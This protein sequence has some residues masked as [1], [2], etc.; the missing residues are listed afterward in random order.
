MAEQSMWLRI[1]EIIVGLIIVILGGYAIAY[2]G[3]AAATLIAFLAVGLIVLSGIE[4]A[5]VFAL[6]ISGWRRLLNLILSAIA[7]LLAL[8]GTR[9]PAYLWNLDPRL[10]RS[11]GV[12]LRRFSGHR[13]QHSG[14]DNRW[15]NRR[16]T[17][18][19]RA[20]K[21]HCRRDHGSGVTGDSPD[22]IRV[23][24]DSIRSLGK[25]GVTP[26]LPSFFRDPK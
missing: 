9:R 1:A 3:V 2:P 5:Q 7:F 16:Y 13:T 15:H 6:D 25:M 19:C 14:D 23:N 11:L 21:S 18:F 26:H 17:R 4:F 24:V 22:H 12:D 10:A 20:D 8:A